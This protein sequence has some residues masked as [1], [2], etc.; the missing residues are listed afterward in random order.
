MARKRNPLDPNAVSGRVPDVARRYGIGTGTVSDAIRTGE[1]PA[2]KLGHS[3][4]SPLVIFF[5]DA[6]RWIESY[7]IRQQR[8]AS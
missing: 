7:R 4:R 8:T 6:D 2:S 5:A 1:L 3:P